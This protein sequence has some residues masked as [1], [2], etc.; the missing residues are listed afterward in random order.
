VYRALGEHKH[1]VN[2]YGATFKGSEG[3]ANIFMEKC[4][5]L[6]KKIYD[7]YLLF[8]FKILFKLTVSVYTGNSVF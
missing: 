6:F 5:K 1:I 4:G 7:L 8:W 2:H 3:H